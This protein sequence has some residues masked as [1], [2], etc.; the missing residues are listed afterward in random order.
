MKRYLNI[1]LTVASIAGTSSSLTFAQSR[2]ADPNRQ[3]QVEPRR[4]A[5]FSLAE[6]GVEV[7][8]DSRLI[9]MMASLEAAGLI[10]RGPD[11]SPQL[12]ARKSGPTWL[13]W[14]RI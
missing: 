1:L 7:Q 5:G 10:P 4:A 2:P 8:P 12:F 3:P 11:K 13:V 6:F 9:I 14:I